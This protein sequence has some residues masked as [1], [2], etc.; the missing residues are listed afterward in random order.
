KISPVKRLRA[1]SLIRLQFQYPH[2]EEVMAFISQNRLKVRTR[3]MMLDCS[4]ELVVSHEKSEAYC[5]RLQSIDGV[6]IYKK[7]TYL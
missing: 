5:N 6:Q 3:K 1:V 4:I 2:L 7:D